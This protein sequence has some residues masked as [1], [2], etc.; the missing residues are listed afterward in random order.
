MGTDTILQAASVERMLRPE[1]TLAAKRGWFDGDYALGVRIW[2]DHNFKRIGV[3]GFIEGHVAQMEFYPAS[4]SG[5]VLMS[6]DVMDRSGFLS[7]MRA[8]FRSKLDQVESAISL[9][10]SAQFPVAGSYRFKNSRNGVLDF[11]D[12]LYGRLT[13]EAQGSDPN[14]RWAHSPKQEPFLLV[15]QKQRPVADFYT[16]RMKSG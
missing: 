10:K 14:E 16:F 3:T 11:E 15:F 1:T 2:G 8:I 6:T 13:V 9:P 4:K 7:E 5:W 12:N